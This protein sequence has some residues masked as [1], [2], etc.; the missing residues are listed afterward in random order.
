MDDKY[1]SNEMSERDRMEHTESVS[2][3]Q[4][5]SGHSDSL[6]SYSYTNRET[7]KTTHEGDYYESKAAESQEEMS[8]KQPAMEHTQNAWLGICLNISRLSL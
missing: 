8:Y 1:N 3:D 7:S 4:E 6:Y 2:A 5:V